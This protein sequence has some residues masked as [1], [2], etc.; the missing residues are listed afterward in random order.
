MCSWKYN[1][2]IIKLFTSILKNKRKLFVCGSLEE[3]KDNVEIYT[4]GDCEINNIYGFK[5]NN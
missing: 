2:V 4:Y 3:D 5:L 1:W